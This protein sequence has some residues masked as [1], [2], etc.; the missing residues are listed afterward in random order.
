MMSS[1]HVET[2]HALPTPPAS[3]GERWLGDLLKRIEQL[4]NRCHA[5][6][7]SRVLPCVIKGKQTLIHERGL[8]QRQPVMFAYLQ[9]FCVDNR[10][11]LQEDRRAQ[12]VP[13][14]RERRQHLA[15]VVALAA[16]LLAPGLVTASES[17]N[18]ANVLHDSASSSAQHDQVLYGAV[19]NLPVRDGG[20][21]FLSGPHGEVANILRI[22]AE[23]RS[24]GT[25][26]R[27]STADL[28]VPDRPLN[29]VVTRFDYTFP[30]N[31][32]AQR[33]SY[34]EGHNFRALGHHQGDKVVIDVLAGGGPFTA[35]RL[36]GPFD[37]V[38][39]DTVDMHLLVG[40]GEQDSFGLMKASYTVGMVTEMPADRLGEYGSAYQH[41]TATSGDC[42]LPAAPVGVAK[43]RETP[44]LSAEADT[45]PRSQ[46]AA[47]LSLAALQ[48][49]GATR[50]R[51]V[52]AR[53]G[54]EL[55]GAADHLP[56]RDQGKRFLDTPQG[57]VLDIE[58]VAAEV[59]RLGQMVTINTSRM[60][61][62]MRHLNPR[63]RRYDHEFSTP[64]GALRF[65]L[66]EGEGFRALGFHDGERVVLDVLEGGAL[67]A[68]R[69][70]GTYDQVLNEDSQLMDALIADGERDGFGTLKAAFVVGVVSRMATDRR[71][72][73]GE[74]YAS[75]VDSV[76]RVIDANDLQQVNANDD[77]DPVRST[78][79]DS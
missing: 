3:A 75:A 63:V 14:A 43:P 33:F 44:L 50:A 71:D 47:L 1:R 29:D 28:K 60:K 26:T 21:R 76:A 46:P 57:E 52:S 56:V 68:P 53:A 19:A 16:S 64:T 51:E 13:V 39:N 4:A 79:R 45:G 5:R 66:Y 69:L 2:P 23:T 30:A 74:A 62:P 41:A 20:T 55:Y 32:G 42:A 24:R 34:F 18:A 70:W 58:T 61:L 15:P 78:R 8:A 27:V 54:D 22:A 11:R 77:Q 6:Y 65:S 38:K 59:K 73:Y 17:G 25:Q 10:V 7:H 72:A 12:D 48:P 35:P 9:R 37:Q 49:A 67:S 40:N 36:W 31:C